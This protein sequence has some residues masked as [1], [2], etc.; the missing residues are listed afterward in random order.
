M[1]SLRSA[2][3]RQEDILFGI[4][5]QMGNLVQ[6]IATMGLNVH[7]EKALNE[8]TVEHSKVEAN[9]KSDRSRHDELKSTQAAKESDSLSISQAINSVMNQ[10][11]NA[12]T[13]IRMHSLLLQHLSKIEL[14]PDPKIIRI[15]DKN[16]DV[17]A[18][19]TPLDSKLKHARI[20]TP[21]LEWDVEQHFK[22]NAI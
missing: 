6:S 12:D 18:T 13:R 21:T 22:T 5:K 10:A 17:I 9:L 4:D 3:V 7:L 19:I 14:S 1:E 2:I 11:A 15:Y 16:D 20:E 8:L